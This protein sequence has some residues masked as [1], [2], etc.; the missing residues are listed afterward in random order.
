LLFCPP[1]PGFPAPR[2]A[3]FCGGLVGRDLG[4]GLGL[5]PP[6]PPGSPPNIRP[7][8]VKPAATKLGFFLPWARITCWVLF[9]FRPRT[10]EVR[11]PPPAP[12]PPSPPVATPPSPRPP[13]PPALPSLNSWGLTPSRPT[14]FWAR[15]NFSFPTKFGGGR[16]RQLLFRWVLR[17]GLAFPPC[18]RV[19]GR[20]NRAPPPGEGFPPRPETISLSRR[21]P[22]IRPK[23]GPPPPPPGPQGTGGRP[24][25]LLGFFQ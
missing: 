12:V 13:V 23:T 7:E 18:F 21:P 25:D 8:M 11:S 16:L 24:P 4:G 10:G 19:V 2:I 9:L 14:T 5:G 15:E 22:K 3:G 17:G 6:G 20:P 1:P